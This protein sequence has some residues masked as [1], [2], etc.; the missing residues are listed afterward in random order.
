MGRGASKT[1]EESHC[2]GKR[3]IGGG[4]KDTVSGRLIK[5]RSTRATRK[6][7]E[8]VARVE[9]LCLLLDSSALKRLTSHRRGPVCALKRL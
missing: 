9:L 6:G 7:S 4:G 3:R 1:K 2:K 5:L 8:R